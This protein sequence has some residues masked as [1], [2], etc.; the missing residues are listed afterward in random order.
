M[1]S[2]LLH[3][4]S[5]AAAHS[6]SSSIRTRSFTLTPRKAHSAL[7]YARSQA[8]SLSQVITEFSVALLPSPYRS[9]TILWI[10][11]IP[12]PRLGSPLWLRYGTAGMARFSP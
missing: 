1:G 8:S 3:G 11:V 12:Q 9:I 5:G 6:C 4:L 7:T 2:Y 10:R